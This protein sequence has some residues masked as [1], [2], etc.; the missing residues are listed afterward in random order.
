M[1]KPMKCEVCDLENQTGATFCIEC[2]NRLAFTGYTSK[3]RHNVGKTTYWPVL[4]SGA[5]NEAMKEIVAQS[6]LRQGALSRSLTLNNG[7]HYRLDPNGDGT[8]TAIAAGY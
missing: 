5:Y 8:S 6:P 2:G 1:G 7:K 4:L 3:L